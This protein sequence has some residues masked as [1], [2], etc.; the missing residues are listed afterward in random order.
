MVI[1]QKKQIMLSLKKITLTLE[2]KG[3]HIKAVCV[4]LNNK[5][6]DATGFDI[7]F[8]R[9][10]QPHLWIRYNY[11]QMRQASPKT[12]I[13]CIR[14]NKDLCKKLECLQLYIVQYDEFGQ[15]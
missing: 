11:N 2:F 15:I 4:P 14:T 5:R 1:N 6:C 9:L 13:H 12:L 7:T 8:S 10:N 3:G